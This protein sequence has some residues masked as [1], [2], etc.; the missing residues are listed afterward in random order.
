[1][2]NQYFGDRLDYINYGVLRRLTG[3]GELSAA[4]CWMMRPDIPRNRNGGR[5]DPK[6]AYLNHPDWWRQFDPP[7]FDLLHDAIRVQQDRHVRHI[8]E[9]GLLP[10]TSFYQALLSRDRVRDR[11][12]REKYLTNF[13]ENEAAGK[14]LVLLDPDTGIEVAHPQDR[15]SYLSK[16][17]IR[18]VYEA[19]HSVL[20]FQH[21]E[22]GK[23]RE[24][25]GI[26]KAEAVLECTG[27]N[28]AY[29]LYDG[30]VGLILVPQPRREEFFDKIIRAIQE[31]D[32]GVGAFVRVL[33]RRAPPDLQAEA[34]AV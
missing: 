26:A 28:R 16:A 7:L 22:N 12:E 25:E 10:K 8:E 11:I 27:A 4:V 30:T 20:I 19:G 15:Y 9:S 29:F 14:D 21:P 18:R 32:G 3:M 5:P 31:D 24:A 23:T 34:A 13:L 6:I 17:E 2:R 33:P 1:M